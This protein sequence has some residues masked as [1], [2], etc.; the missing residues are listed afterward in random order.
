RGKKRIQPLEQTRD[1]DLVLAARGSKRLEQRRSRYLRRP[2]SP[3]AGL[4][5]SPHEILEADVFKSVV[6]NRQLLARGIN[7][8]RRIELRR[9]D[10]KVD[11]GHDHSEHDDAIASLDVAPN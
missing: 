8:T 9:V 6:A 11:V 2:P 1:G 7:R 5:Q 10:A 4:E 3:Q